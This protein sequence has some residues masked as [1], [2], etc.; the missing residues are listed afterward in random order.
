MRSKR[1]LSIIGILAGGAIVGAASIIV[2]DEVT[3]ATSTD[4]FCTSCHSMAAVAADSVQSSHQGNPAGVRA[5]CA[6]CHIVRGNWFAE[7]YHIA[8]AALRDNIAE[9]TRDYG[10]AAVWIRRR[11]ELADKVRADMRGQDAVTCRRCHFAAAI[12]PASDAGRAAHAMLQQGGATC[13]DCH[14]NLAH[15]PSAA[16]G[17]SPR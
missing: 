4:A 1:W 17:T 6:D 16:G 3:R 9:Y 12:R 14:S 11:A 13:I 10:D 8:A 15:A 2:V 7:N 5:G